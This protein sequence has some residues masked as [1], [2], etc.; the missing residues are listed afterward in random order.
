MPSLALLAL[1][2]SVCRS[3]KALYWQRSVL[4]SAV[5]VVVQCSGVEYTAETV[6]GLKYAGDGQAV[7]KS[8]FDG[9]YFT[10]LSTNI[11][12]GPG[13]RNCPLV[14]SSFPPNPG[15]AG[16]AECITVLS[17]HSLVTWLPSPSTSLLPCH[18]SLWLELSFVQK[19]WDLFHP[20]KW[21]VS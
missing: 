5:H 3:F 18:Y 13:G 4:C 21:N 19:L 6:E 17:L 16:P 2:L 10:S 9:I 11:G 12:E 14:P 8:T 1:L 15:S 7:I 20:N